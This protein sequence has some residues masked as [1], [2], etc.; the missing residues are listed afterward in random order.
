MMRKALFVL[1]MRD[2]LFFASPTVT[3]SS[4]IRI[5]P[6]TASPF[7]DGAD[8]LLDIFNICEPRLLHSQAD[9]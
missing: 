4:E 8:R 2:P 6:M 7:G 3:T 5:N 9:T 1:L